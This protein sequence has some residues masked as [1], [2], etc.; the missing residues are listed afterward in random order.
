MSQPQTAVPVP[1]KIIPISRSIPMFWI[2]NP[3]LTIQTRHKPT[4][5]IRPYIELEAGQ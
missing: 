3:P 1:V 2:R 4:E 5:I